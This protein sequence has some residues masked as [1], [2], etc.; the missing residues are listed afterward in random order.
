VQVEEEDAN[1]GG[2]RASCVSIIRR[3]RVGRATALSAQTISFAIVHSVVGGC[4]ARRPLRRDLG[5]ERGFG[6]D[7]AFRR[8]YFLAFLAWR[9][10]FS[11][12]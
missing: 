4:Q 3:I 10:S 7:E 6:A 1:L 11:V 9:F 2:Y 12:F 5:R 8:L